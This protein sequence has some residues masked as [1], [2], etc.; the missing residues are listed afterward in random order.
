[1][2]NG[3][4][5]GSTMIRRSQA[6]PGEM[7]ERVPPF[8]I[9]A[10][11]G[12]VGSVLL[13]PDVLDDV[14]LIVGAGDFYDDA[15]SRLF[16]HLSEMHAAGDKVD[17][18]LL[19]DR[20]KTRGDF[21]AVGGAAYLFKTGQSV[22]NAAHAKYYAKIVHEKA[23]LRRLIEAGTEILHDAY[24]S[25]GTP[26]DQLARAEERVFAI[27]DRQTQ[28]EHTHDMKGVMFRV[29]DAVEAR[30]Q[31]TAGDGVPTGFT[32]LDLMLGGLRPGQVI[33]AA[34][35]TG[36][37]KSAFALNIAEHMAIDLGRPVL[38]VSLEMS[39]N[40]LGERLLS[41]RARVD[42][43]RLRN[44]TYTTEQQKQL[45][46][47]S[48]KIAASPLSIDDCPS[49]SA[50]QI[51]ALA[52]R[53]KRRH[54]LDL[55]VVDYLQLVSPDRRG[56]TRQ[57]EVSQVSRRLKAL[58][59]ELGAP[60]IALAQLNR[61]TGEDGKKPKLSHLRESGAIEQ[62]ADVVLFVHRDGYYSDESAPSGHGE[63]AEVSIAKQ[64]NGPRS[65]VKVVWFGAYVRFDNTAKAE[66]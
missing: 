44:G 5:K 62:D 21:E 66:F 47:A 34:G 11:M 41:S 52:R 63:E 57:D 30:K 49:R 6:N 45:V 22:P 48:A 55:L 60:V 12:V 24:A 17:V 51:A 58:A 31:A 26:A 29:L 59:R 32:E 64:R 43:Y 25:D 35:K 19:T 54:G 16:R 4:G 10:E 37:G 28:T 8:S 40:E 14:A 20:L 53:H 46:A 27:A 23:V 9:E 39:V 65:C 3:S 18:T 15:N 2:T 50:S 33:I 36:M 13:K 7:L 56:E 1:M 42:S 38:F 61:Q